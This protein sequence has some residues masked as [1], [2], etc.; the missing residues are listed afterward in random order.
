MNLWSRNLSSWYEKLLYPIM[1]QL[2]FFIIGC[3]LMGLFPSLISLYRLYLGIVDLHHWSIIFL[4]NLSLIFLFGY[5]HSL[6]L[7]CFPSKWIKCFSYVILL[8]AFAFFLF[9][10]LVFGRN[11]T[12]TI[13]QMIIETTGNESEEFFQTFMF[14]NKAYLCYAIVSFFVLFIFLTE[15]FYEKKSQFR[16]KCHSFFVRPFFG[17]FLSISILGGIFS[18]GIY[19]NLF[20]SQTVDEV[21]YWELTA[22]VRPQDPISNLIYSGYGLFCSIQEM[23]NAEKYIVNMS[24]DNIIITQD[25]LDIVLIIGESFI[26]RHSSLYGYP[27]ETTPIMRQEMKEGRLFPFSNVVSPTNGTTMAIRQMLYTNSIAAKESWSKSM[28]APAVFKSAGYTVS[29]W[30][31]QKTQ[32]VD[33]G[34]TF[35]LNGLLYNKAISRISYSFVNDSSFTYDGQL[36]TDF[37]KHAFTQQSKHNFILFHLLGQHIDWSARYPQETRYE[38]FTKD[39]IFRSELWMT[40]DKRADIAKYDNALRYGDVVIGQV[41]ALYRHRNAVVV[42]LSDHGEEV[43]DYRDSK[44]RVEDK[45]GIELLQAQ[46]E[47]PFIIWCSDKYKE[48]NPQQIERIKKYIDRPFSIDNLPHL[49]FGLGCIQSPYYYVERDLLSPS[50]KPRKRII[51]MKYDYDEFFE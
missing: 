13:L 41:L 2:P 23:S 11:I 5:L 37:E 38:Y 1:R 50:F 26:K 16:A 46:Y 32:W 44:G 24:K 45:M 51:E 15:W 40:D 18:S 19:F 14:S 17:I 42:F 36:I 7:Y 31:N 10:F 29:F 27:L 48:H 12:P 43:F 20:R 30:D 47:I 9:L 35:S 39:S 28:Y 22:Y 3:M 49:L 21:A 6:L 25:S 33:A 8:S 34:F 4:G